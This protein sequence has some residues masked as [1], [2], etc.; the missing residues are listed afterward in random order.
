[1]RTRLVRGVLLLSGAIAIAVAVVAWCPQG[2]RA[3]SEVPFPRPATIE[4][5]VDFW[6]EIFTSYSVRDFLLHD[7][8]HI[9]RVYQVFHLP[10][11]GQPSRA[12]IGWVNA[13]L[14]TKYGD[15]LER[16]ATGAQPVGYEERRVAAM[17]KGE[18]PAA[19]ELAAQNLRV[20]EGLRERFREGLV[21][22]RYYRASMERIFEGFGLPVELV[23]LAQI[24]SGFHTRAKS[25]AGATGIW[26]FTRATGRKY[27][28]ITRHRDDRLNPTR[29]TEAAAKL[30]RYNYQVLGDWPLAITAYNYGTGGT[31]RAAEQCNDDYCK[32]LKTYSGPHFGFA[33]K[34]YYAEFLAALQVHRYEDEYFPGLES[35][36]AYVEHAHQ[37]TVHRG[38]TPGAIATMFGISTRQ[39]LDANDVSDP[40]HIRAGATLVIPVSGALAPKID[41]G[42][43]R[44]VH[45]SSP[46]LQSAAAEKNATHELAAAKPQASKPTQ[47]VARKA[48]TSKPKEQAAAE[49][50]KSGAQKS[51]TMRRGD[52]LYDIARDHRVAVKALMESNRIRNPRD[53]RPGT[54]LVIPDV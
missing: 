47:Q 31:A 41:R 37:Y 17:F 14:K 5:N 32:I 40:R 18:S 27:L 4:P 9:W 20:Q 22:S 35:E 25:G 28:K 16:L 19:Y 2:A 50:Q 11:D 39:L 48:E 13:Y 53:L 23:T 44:G 15:I 29:S 12:E 10:G 33:V 52:T 6:V 36:K 54:K 24:E 49:Q 26:Q 7:K 43:G 21:R 51:Y 46:K 42:R 1:V 30:L 34:N 38:D 45:R 8:D 3:A